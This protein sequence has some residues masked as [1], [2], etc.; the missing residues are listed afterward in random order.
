MGM[1]W[2]T[3][4]VMGVMVGVVQAFYGIGILKNY[5]HAGKVRQAVFDIFSASFLKFAYQI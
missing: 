1:W 5:G 3:V 4:A 2:E